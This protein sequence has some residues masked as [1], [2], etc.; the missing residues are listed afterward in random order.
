MFL[1]SWLAIALA[2]FGPLHWL[3]RAGEQP[4]WRSDFKT[5]LAYWFLP[6]FICGYVAFIVRAY[7]VGYTHLDRTISDTTRSLAEAPIL[8][9]C[10]LILVITDLI[11][12]WM[13]RLF[14]RNPLWRFHCIHHAPVQVD[15]FTGVRF[16]PINTI[17][18]TTLVNLLVGFLAF[19]PT[20]FFSLVPFNILFSLLVHANLNWTF[21]PFRYVLASP[22]FHR[23]HHTYPD[24]GGNK[25]F[26]PN[27]PILD[28]IFGTFHMPKGRLPSVFGTPYD[29]VP[30]R[31]MGQ[32]WYPFRGLNRG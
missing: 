31:L 8:V 16:H 32:L 12:Y 22:V 9:Q 20:A 2:L 5:D 30:T 4:F 27:F 19:S 29:H 25:N 14:H 15:W 17:L 28:V 6:P 7:I 1:V 3:L 11:Q 10:V 26:A 24:E 21:G 23:W 18:Y 13:H